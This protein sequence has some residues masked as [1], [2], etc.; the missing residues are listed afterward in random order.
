MLDQ[1]LDRPRR[2][3]AERADGVAFDLL[4]HVEQRVDLADVGIAG[5]QAFH[6]APHPAGA[7][8]AR[9][10]LATAFMLVDIADP[11]D[12]LNDVGRLV[13]HDRGGSTETR[14]DG[15]QPRSEEHTYELQSLISISHA[16]FI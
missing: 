12:R 15:F 1:A 8:A 14:T 7:L 4:G 10:A 13:H 2:G 6:H 3:V 5:A 9:G 11:A 16:G